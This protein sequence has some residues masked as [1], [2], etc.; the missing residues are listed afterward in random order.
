MMNTKNFQQIADELGLSYDGIHLARLAQFTIQD[1][2]AKGASIYVDTFGREIT[3]V[4]V[5]AQVDDKHNEFERYC[6]NIG[7]WRRTV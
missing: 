6:P 2:P 5:Q 1:G 3:S 4:T 7:Q